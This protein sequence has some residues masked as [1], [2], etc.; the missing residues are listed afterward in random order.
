MNKK[1]QNQEFTTNSVIE[2]VEEGD[3]R[4]VFIAGQECFVHHLDP[5]DYSYFNVKESDLGK[6]RGSDLKSSI[7]LCLGNEYS[8][9]KFELVEE[10]NF[11]HS[12]QP[13]FIIEI[14]L[15]NKYWEGFFGL[16]TLLEA[17]I[18]QVNNAANFNI[19]Q[20]ELEDVHKKVV[21]SY[22]ISTEDLLIVSLNSAAEQYDNLV[23]QAEKALVKQGIERYLEQD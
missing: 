23:T 10:A 21:I 16:T 22:K 1:N 19:V 11:W 20:S 6:I 17:I 12:E 9:E 13:E 15:Y 14:F 18:E 7:V 3:M 5:G 4:S 2:V 8:S